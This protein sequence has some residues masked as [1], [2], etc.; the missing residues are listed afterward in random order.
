VSDDLAAA[1]D[2][3]SGDSIAQ[4]IAN[5][6]LSTKGSQ[7]TKIYFLLRAISNNEFNIS[8]CVE[9]ADIRNNI[10]HGELTV[11]PEHFDLCKK[12]AFWASE[13]FVLKVAE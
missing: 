2:C 8:S 7:R 10:A 6:S 4:E 3:P 13:A 1:K 5:Y 12:L 11:S 9:I